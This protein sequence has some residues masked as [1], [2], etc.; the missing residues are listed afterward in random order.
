MPL[1]GYVIGVI[2]LLALLAAATALGAGVG[3]FIASFSE[4]DA[5]RPMGI[6]IG[7]LFGFSCGLGMCF[8]LIDFAIE[9]IQNR[10]SSEE[11]AKE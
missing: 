4:S 5:S 3:F 7:S 9:F 8:S 6:V 2:I 11:S 10:T 1:R